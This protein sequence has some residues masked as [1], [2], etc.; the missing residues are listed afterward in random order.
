MT[1]PTKRLLVDDHGRRYPPFTNKF[2]ATG[3]CEPIGF[4]YFNREERGAA[5]D[6]LP[7]S[8]RCPRPDDVGLC[9]ESTVLSIRNGAGAHADEHVVRRPGLREHDGR[10][11]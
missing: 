2:T 5:G 4:S 7:T 10:R 8:R 3:S 1:F 6:R 11:P 9:W